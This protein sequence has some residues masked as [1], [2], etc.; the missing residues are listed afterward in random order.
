MRSSTALTRLALLGAMA[1]AGARLSADGPDLDLKVR[2]GLNTMQKDLH[3][4]KAFGLAVSATFPLWKDAGL[5]VDFGY[6]YLPGRA[7]DA[8]PDP[9]APIWY[10][11]G[12][13]ILTTGPNGSPLFLQAAQSNGS[14][15]SR[16]T[17]FEGF[18]VRGSYL[19]PIPA[20]SGLSWHAGLSLDRYKSS[21]QFVGNAVPVYKDGSSVKNLGSNAYE[22]WALSRKRAALQLGLHAGVVY[23]V[24]E[25]HKLEFNIRNIGYGLQDFQ[26]L[27]YTGRAAQLSDKNGRGF[28]FEVGLTVKL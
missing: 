13:T 16:K 23:Q 4:N 26:P 5:M 25:N 21:N 6:D 7:W 1:L 9:K 17:G 24:Q 20:V 27:A 14:A 18:S 2:A 3:D 8:L 28:V 11:Q 22:G 19:A 10:N 12:G 15:D